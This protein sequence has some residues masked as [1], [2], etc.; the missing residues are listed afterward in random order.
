MKYINNG[1]C[2]TVVCSEHDVETFATRWPCFGSRREIEF[3]FDRQ[4]GDLIDLT[5]D[6]DMDA[7]GVLALSQD[8]Y[9]WGASQ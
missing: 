7:S 3:Q 1:S 4:S 6:L 5:N 9:T 2:F 8:A